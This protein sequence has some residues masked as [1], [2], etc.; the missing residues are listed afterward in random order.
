MTLNPWPVLNRSDP[1]DQ[2]RQAHRRIRAATTLK[3]RKDAIRGYTIR[4][5]RSAGRREETEGSLQPGKSW[6]I[7]SFFPEDLFKMKPR[8][9][10][11][12]VLATMVGG[13]VVYES[14][15]WK[16]SQVKGGNDPPPLFSCRACCWRS[17]YCL[18][19]EKKTP[20]AELCRRGSYADPSYV[21]AH[22]KSRTTARFLPPTW[23]PVDELEMPTRGGSAGNYD[24]ISPSSD[25]ATMIAAA[26]A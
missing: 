23:D 26:P 14:P 1:P 6:P 13:K 21:H 17:F 4:R 24:V 19:A 8:Y 10:N 12:E 11:E 22:S 18:L 15:R 20:D 9:P 2:R 16:S 5:R 25:E 7:S 3:R